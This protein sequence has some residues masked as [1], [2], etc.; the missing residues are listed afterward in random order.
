MSDEVLFHIVVRL[1]GGDPNERPKQSAY[2]AVSFFVSV[3]QSLLLKSI[4]S[5]L[6]Y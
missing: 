3:H 6:L 2:H 5:L 4:L 1:K